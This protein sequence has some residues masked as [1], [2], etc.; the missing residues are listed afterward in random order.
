MSVSKTLIGLILLLTITLSS[1]TGVGYLLAIAIGVLEVDSRP[2]AIVALL[3]MVGLF[4]ASVG[5]T[6]V[7]MH[8]QR[9]D[10]GSA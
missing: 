3:T 6:Q 10:R 4:L 1:L 8:A 7:L 9:F 5:W 2:V